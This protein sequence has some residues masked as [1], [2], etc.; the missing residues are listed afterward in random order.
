[1]LKNLPHSLCYNNMTDVIR[2]VMLHT[3]ATYFAIGTDA[4]YTTN[5]HV[6]IWV[7]GETVN[8]ALRLI[9][10]SGSTLMTTSIL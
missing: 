1:M 4:W 3:P 8:V 2:E 6:D 7:T 5:L 9:L 10:Y